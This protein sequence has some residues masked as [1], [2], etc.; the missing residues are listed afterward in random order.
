MIYTIERLTDRETV[1]MFLNQDRS[2]TAYAL[3]DLD[4][5]FWPA[6]K[7]YGA[8]ADDA[9][10]AVLLL[11]TGLTP[12]VLTA[13]GD[14]AGVRAMLEA[15][16]LPDEVYYLWLPQLGAVLGEQYDRTHEHAEWRMVLDRDAFHPADL[17]TVRPIDPHMADTLTALYQH[18]AG[19]GESIVAFDPWQIAHGVFYGV[20]QANELVATAGTHVYS[21]AEG[22]TAVGNVFTRPDCRGRGYAT[23]CT[24]AVV[25][26]ALAA[27]ADTIVLNVR[28]DNAAALRVY[29][30]LG[31]RRYRRFLEGPALRHNNELT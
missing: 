31:F 25:R 22:V 6:S 26:D 28:D 17:D 13:F 16:P 14:A 10:Q 2:L 1:R 15:L 3:G 30:K 29:E 23:Q 4:D 11:Y 9:L 8:Y 24:A 19:P 18:A 20:W 7:F 12:P 27:G 21:V 5:A